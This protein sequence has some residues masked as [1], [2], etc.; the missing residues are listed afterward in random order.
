M[1]E[2]WVQRSVASPNGGIEG[3]VGNSGAN[4]D[5]L[6]LSAGRLCQAVFVLA[7]GAAPDD[8]VDFVKTN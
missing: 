8:G 6:S 3:P 7:L 1:D 4:W 2:S 5:N